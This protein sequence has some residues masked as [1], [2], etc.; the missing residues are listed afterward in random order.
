MKTD[1]GGVKTDVAAT[2]SDLEATKTQLKRM[3]GDAGVMSGLIAT[4]H[5]ELEVLK[6]KGRPELS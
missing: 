2:K 6:H 4:N 1:V 3:M 5:D